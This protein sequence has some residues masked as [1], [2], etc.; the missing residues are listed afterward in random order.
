MDCYKDFAHIY[1][2]L[3]Y[4]DINY[5]KWAEVILKI[6]SDFSVERN[7][8][9]DLACGT[10]NMTK[11]I[12]KGFKNIWAVDLSE[13]MLI[14]AEEK[15]RTNKINNKLICQDICHLELNKKFDLITCSLDSTNYILDE[16]GLR[17]YFE[18]VHKHLKDQGIFVFDINSYYKLTNILGNNIF[19]FDNGDTVY[20]WENTLEDD[21]VQ[22]Y[23]TFFQKEGKL[24]RRFDE[25]HEERAYKEELI[26]KNLSEVGFQIINKL[27]NYENKE[28]DKTTERIVYVVRKSRDYKGEKTI[29]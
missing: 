3:I 28:I 25:E 2:K 15:L 19:N 9:L 10:G 24:Y 13:D 14:E 23:I 22:M 17:A 6:C 1:D 26:E 20:I 18:G 5:K 11:E 27:D 21:I 16:D 7:D 8:Y 29:G 12:G 4:E